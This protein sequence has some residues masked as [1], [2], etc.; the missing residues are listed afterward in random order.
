MTFNQLVYVVEVSKTKSINATARALYV[1]QSSVSTS[2]K[3]LEDELGILIFN[4]TNRGISTTKEGEMLIQSANHI[5]Q[6]WKSLKER[7]T[8][9]G[10]HKQHFSVVMHHSTFATQAYAKIVKEFGLA[11]YE[12]S[13]Y[14]TKTK[15]V[16]E[17]VNNGKSELGILYISNY[18]QD[19]YEKVLREMN[20]CFC[21]IAEYEVCAYIGKSHPL[22]GKQEVTLEEL[23][24][25]PCLIFDQDENSSFYF[26]EEMISTYQYKNVIRTSDRATTIDLLQALDGYSI[27]IGTVGDETSVNGI[28]TVKIKTEERIHVGYLIRKGSQLSDIA[29]KFVAYFKNSMTHYS[30]EMV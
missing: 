12:Y 15:E 24:Q 25:Y 17:Q 30:H 8:G 6:Q 16:L 5:L 18:N 26:Y 20:L 28:Q 9:E 7:Y 3:E 2:I 21:P 1:S 29:E 27:G 22:V 23:E 4:R 11:G 14:E 10:M 13:I 19:Y